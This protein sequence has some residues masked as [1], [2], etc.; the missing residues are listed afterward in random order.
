MQRG[1]PRQLTVQRLTPREFQVA[2]LSAHGF[3]SKRTA[4]DLHL[5]PGPVRA[6]LSRVLGKLGLRGCAQLPAVWH[7]L[8]QVGRS[9]ELEPEARQLTSG[10]ELLIFQSALDV[11]EPPDALSNAERAV[12]IRVLAGYN[13]IEIAQ[14]RGTSARTVANQLATMFRKFRVSSKAELAALSL[15]LGLGAVE[16]AGA[17]NAKRIDH[18]KVTMALGNFIG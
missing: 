7:C 18:D 14:E 10:S 2:R 6:V 9:Y 17:A 4:S 16:H 3:A 15:G 13:N 8:S 11:R 12:L 1:D 5:Q